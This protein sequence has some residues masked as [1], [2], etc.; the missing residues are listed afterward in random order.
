[1]RKYSFLALGVFGNTRALPSCPRNRTSGCLVRWL[2]RGST[3]RQMF[4][5]S[6][7]NFLFGNRS[8][9]SEPQRGV[10]TVSDTSYL[11]CTYLT[12]PKNSTPYSSQ[13]L[14][15]HQQKLESGERASE[16]ASERETR[17]R[18]HSLV[19]RLECRNVTSTRRIEQK[20]STRISEPVTR[21]AV[22]GTLTETQNAI[23]VIFP[24]ALISRRRRFHSGR[25]RVSF[26]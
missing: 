15:T 22:L 10:K 14:D 21:D 12:K 13:Q 25:S 3:L 18:V 2:L 1:M 11:R 20:L 8:A 16:R 23:T 26:I 4:C 6:S 17:R 9:N 19:T 7:L 5:P 24:R